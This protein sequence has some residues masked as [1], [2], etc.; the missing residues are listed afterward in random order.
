[1]NKPQVFSTIVARKEKISSKVYELSLRLVSPERIHF[2]AGQNV[3]MRISPGVNRSMSIASPP[4]EEGMI[5]M[6]HDISPMGPG[7]RWTLGAKVGDPLSVVGPLGIFYL[8]P[9]SPRKKIL[10]ATGTGIAPFRSMLYDYEARGLTQP[11]S[12]YWGLR[13]E[14]DMFWHEELERFA[15]KHPNVSYMLTLSQPA[16]TWTGKRGRVTAYIYNEENL[17]QNDWYLCGSKEMIDEV[18]RELL[19]RGVPKEQIKKELFY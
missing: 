10:V 8:D 13:R 6:C 7:S 14:E 15:K 5:L 18:S 2:A 1:M 12:L 4:H 16:D 9:E 3:M 17:A 11:V 19:S